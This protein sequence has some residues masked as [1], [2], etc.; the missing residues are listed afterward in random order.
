MADSAAQ[1]SS[2]TG[3]AIPSEENLRR[4]FDLSLDLLCVAG[5]DGYFKHINPAFTRALGYRAEDLLSKAFVE[6]V[7]PEDQAATIAAVEQLAQGLDIVDFENRYR[8]ADGT[9]RWLAWRSTSVP[10]EGLIFAVA[11]DITD[12]KRLQALATRQAGDLARSY[13][14]LEE[15]AAIASHDL[16]APLRAVHNL[17]DWIEQDLPDDVSPQAVEHLHTLRD[18]VDLMTSLVSDLLDYSRIGR[19]EEVIVR[20]DTAAL[21]ANIT[22]LLGSPAG[23]DIVADA[24]LPTFDTVQAAL[25]QALRNLIANAF[26]HHDR[27][28][29]LIVVSA[30]RRD[31]MWEFRVADDGPGMPPDARARA[32]EPL[33]SSSS[34]VH[35]GTGMGLSLVKRIVERFGGRVWMEHGDGRGM[36]VCFTWPERITL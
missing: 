30:Q 16:Q 5:L 25:E 26:E 28:S 33:W 17:A 8:A 1:D 27:D 29:G 19:Q 9:W 10:E 14:D 15:F 4:L 31:R 20:T 3:G 35:R 36:T 11:R 34:G 22:S 23:F 24:S 18:R 7:H 6:F 2:S 32:F 12:H 21:V 13:A